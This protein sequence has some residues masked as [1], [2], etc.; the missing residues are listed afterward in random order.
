MIKFIKIIL[1]TTLLLNIL[2]CGLYKP[3]DARKTSPNA[4]KRVAKNLEEGRGFRLKNKIGNKGGVFEFAS[5]NAMM[6][7]FY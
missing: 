5:S 6:E 3:V 4:S 2:G 1:F 7:S